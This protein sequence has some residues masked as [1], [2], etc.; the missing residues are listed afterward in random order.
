MFSAEL[1]YTLEA[2][3]REAT[4]RKHLFFCV[5]HLLFALLFDDSV[6]EIIRNCGG[7]VNL[8]K[9]ELEEFFNSQIE[10][11]GNGSKGSRESLEASSHPS[12]PVQ[13][14]AV[15]R[16]LRKAVAQAQ[17]SGKQLITAKE[18]LIAI[19]SEQDCYGVYALEKQGI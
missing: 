16:V 15:E 1:S 3:F 7:D 8:L 5:E 12:V 17:S 18:V 4:H 19:F 2:A 6:I 10:Q 13:T 14:P 9:K 11:Y